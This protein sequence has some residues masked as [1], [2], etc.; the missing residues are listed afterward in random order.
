MSASR[1]DLSLN[2]QPV[3]WQSLNSQPQAV[4]A[5]PSSAG[6]GWFSRYA[7]TLMMTVAGSIISALAGFAL[8]ELPKQM[9]SRQGEVPKS[10][11]NQASSSGRTE[12]ALSRPFI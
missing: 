11:N 8:R 2:W 6:Q 7:G 5:E 9:A 10:L 1:A 3:N 12:G 4:E